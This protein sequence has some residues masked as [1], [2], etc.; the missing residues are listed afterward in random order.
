MHHSDQGSQFT[1]FAFGRKLR[2]SGILASMGDVGTACDNAV[3]ES[4]FSTLKRE[5][6]HR[7]HFAT[8]AQ[9][10]SAIFEFIE[11]FY[12]RQRRLRPSGWSPQLSSRG[13]TLVHSRHS[14]QVSG[15]RG[16]AQLFA[17]GDTM[18]DPP[19]AEPTH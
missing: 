13:T 17:S 3:A 19:E 11:V 7:V 8:R 5:L 16:Q 9:A 10:R 12:N 14:H 4:F 18:T 6:V 15:Q 1:S 2:E